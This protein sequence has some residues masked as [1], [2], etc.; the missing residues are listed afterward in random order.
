MLSQAELAIESEKMIEVIGEFKALLDEETEAVKVNDLDISEALSGR[1][2]ELTRKYEGHFA[3]IHEAR[4]FLKNLDI[5]LRRRLSEAQQD[6]AKAIEENILALEAARQATRR[7]VSMIVNAAT[8]GANQTAAYGPSGNAQSRYGKSL[9][10]SAA[11]G[12]AAPLMGIS[13]DENL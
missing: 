13:F 4:E 12:A 10:G 8:R 7:V 1:K 2:T 11:H 5:G 3:L 9:T 6:I